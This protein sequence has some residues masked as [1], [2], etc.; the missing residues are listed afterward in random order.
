MLV[1]LLWTIALRFV[2]GQYGRPQ[3]RGLEVLQSTVVDNLGE[4]P[5]RHRQ[6][7]TGVVVRLARVGIEPGRWALSAT[8]PFAA[9]AVSSADEARPMRF[10]VP[11]EILMTTFSRRCHDAAPPARSLV[12]GQASQ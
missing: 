11:P 7:G 10:V 6:D 9:A 5:M 2:L 1:H 4:V 3:K 8:D 12:P